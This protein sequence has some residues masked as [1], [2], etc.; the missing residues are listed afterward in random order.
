MG[1]AMGLHSGAV[2]EV[3]TVIR[4]ICISNNYAKIE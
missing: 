3:I 4:N 1:I 2:L